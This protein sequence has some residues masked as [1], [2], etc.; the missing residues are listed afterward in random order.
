MI[1]FVSIKIYLTAK[2]VKMESQARRLFSCL[3]L[4]P[5]LLLFMLLLLLFR[6]LILP[7]FF[8]FFLCDRTAGRA[9]AGPLA[10]RAPCRPSTLRGETLP[11]SLSPPYSSQPHPMFSLSSPTKHTAAK[12]SLKPNVKSPGGGRLSP[13]SPSTKQEAA[14]LHPLLLFFSSSLRSSSS[15]FT[16]A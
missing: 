13:L 4:L 3:P 11:S 12:E 15:S 10:P 14:P 16:K 1:Y 6:L 7:C 2:R 5:V 9:E 8:F